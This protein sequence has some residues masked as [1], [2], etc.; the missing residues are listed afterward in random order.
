MGNI[1]WLASYP[2]SGNTW[3]RA[4]LLNLITD[5]EAPIDI[6]KMAALTQGDSQA[7]WYAKFDP[8]PPTQ[9]GAEDLA[10]LRPKVHA[11][12]A[13]SSPNS[14]FVKTH[15]ALI[16]NAGA[17]MITQSATAGV[18]YVVRNPLDVA[19]SYA[20]HLGVQVDDIIDLMAE[21]GFATPASETHVP[22][23]HSDWSNHVA[24]WTAVPH[25]A[26][27]VVRYEDMAAK[28]APTFGAVARFLG[29]DT[30]RERL[31][32][33]VR[34]S[35]FKVLKAQEK[36]SGFVERTP[37]QQSFFR[38]GKSGGWRKQLSDAQIR[39][40]LADHSEQMERFDYVPKGY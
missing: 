15:N 1:V 21:R 39:R 9:L 11:A 28:P 40:I 36:K 19:L 5:A 3:L 20:D 24:S 6:N 27:L 2:K 17:A 35:S 22:E 30:S 7:H 12:I 8:R 25:P 31:M 16:E 18:I 37:A 13:A 32:R 29:I 34:F 26:L 38:A 4:F 33:A 14:V 23:H 10:R